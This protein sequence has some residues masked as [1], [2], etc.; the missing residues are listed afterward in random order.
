MIAVPGVADVLVPYQELLIMERNRIGRFPKVAGDRVLELDVEELLNGVD[1]EGV[2]RAPPEERRDRAG[3]RVFCSYSH[4]DEVL[5]AELDTHLTLLQRQSV[6]DLWHDRRIPPG[7]EWEPQIDEE[8]DRAD[9]ILLLVS[10][11]FIASNYC[12]DIEVKRA[13]AR[14]DAGEARVIPVVVR[15]VD[16]HSAP[17]AKCQALPKGAKPVAKGGRGKH[18][19][20]RLG[21]TSLKGS[22]R[23]QRNSG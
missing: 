2:R 9:I 1:L 16:W 19:R 6:I 13:M 23:W 5:R 3:I 20:D 4:K 17:F 7:K 14:H 21:G 8:L 15:D 18:A 12:Y 22:R 10:S 11:D